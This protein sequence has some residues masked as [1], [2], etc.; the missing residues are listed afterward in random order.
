MSIRKQL[1]DNYKNLGK[2]LAPYITD[3][4]NKDENIILKGKNLEFAN[5]EQV[6]WISYYDE[7]R[8]E[9]ETFVKFFNAELLNV[10]ATLFKAMEQYPREL[11]DRMKDK[12]IDGNDEYL[13]VYELYL[14]VKE[15]Y[16]HYV[17]IVETFKARGFALRNITE[18]RINSL[19]DVTI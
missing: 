17:S 7:R 9:L 5:K 19:E 1:G 14:S 2:I 10:R 12:Y 3:L 18:I 13:K 6:A 8:I 4:N 11:S 16:N 15:L